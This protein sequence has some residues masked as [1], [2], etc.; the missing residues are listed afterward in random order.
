MRIFQVDSFTSEIFRGNPAGVCLFVANEDDRWMQNMAN[1]M[2]LSETAFLTKVDDGYGLRWFTP[3]TEVDLCG[4]ATLAAAHVL[5]EMG[6]LDPTHEVKFFTK[7]GVLKALKMG[8]WIQLDFPLEEDAEVDPPKE[9]VDGFNVQFQYVGKN[10]MDY[11]VEVESE[12][13]LRQLKPN[14]EVLRQL[15]NRGIIVTCKSEREEFGFLSRFFAPAL[16]IDEDPV[17]GS[18]HCCLGPYWKRKLHQ[19]EFVAYQASERGGIVKIKVDERVY[20]CG[21]ARTVFS[22]QINL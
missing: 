12:A 14:K 19:D 18:A 3:T 9:L 11:I 6:E 10:R 17:T 2:N 15:G 1:E 4:H 22:G 8:N 21:Q 20:L 16:G 7:S 13:I 5:W